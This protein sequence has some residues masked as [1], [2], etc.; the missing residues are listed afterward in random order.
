MKKNW[1]PFQLPYRRSADRRHI[2]VS[3]TARCVCASFQDPA[4]ERR[5]QFQNRRIPFILYSLEV[6]HSIIEQGGYS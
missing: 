1:T 6:R 5:D 4:K 2:S 3:E